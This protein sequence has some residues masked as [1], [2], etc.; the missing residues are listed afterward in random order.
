MKDTAKD[1]QVRIVWMLALGTLVSGYYSIESH[2]QRAIQAAGQ[3]TQMLFERTVAN[4]QIVREAAHLRIEQRQ[5]DADIGHL[6]KDQGASS[7]TAAF[8]LALQRI[9]SRTHTQVVAIEPERSAASPGPHAA[10]PSDSL[11]GTPVSIRAKGQFADVLRFVE[12]L[13]HLGV[14]LAVSNTQLTISSGARAQ[15]HRP[16]LDATIRATLYRMHA[17]TTSLGGA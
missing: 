13:S 5:I 12:G 6:D 2:Y 16:D 8:L 14:L 3:Q 11:V 10:S 9:G 17:D 4:Q 15:S 7:V 1:V